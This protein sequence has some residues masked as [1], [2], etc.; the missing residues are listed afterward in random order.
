MT[1]LTMCHDFVQRKVF[2]IA[3][4]INNEHIIVSGSKVWRPSWAVGP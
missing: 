3:Q 1:V 2:S 4:N